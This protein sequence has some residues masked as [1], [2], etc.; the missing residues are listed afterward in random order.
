M[1]SDRPSGCSDPFVWE[2][3][4]FGDS[5]DWK[6][7][8]VPVNLPEDA[9][10]MVSLEELQDASLCWRSKR[11]VAPHKWQKGW[12]LW[13]CHLCGSSPT[14]GEGCHCQEA[15]A[16]VAPTMCTH[17]RCQRL[18]ATIVEEELE[19]AATFV[20]EELELVAP[21]LPINRQQESRVNWA[22]GER[23]PVENKRERGAA[24]GSSPAAIC[25]SVWE[26]WELSLSEVILLLHVCFNPFSISLIILT[27]PVDVGGFAEP[28]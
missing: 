12:L 21:F 23:K 19:L 20:E 3:V 25:S 13:Y 2:K 15:A 4:C 14:L 1:W 27:S 8:Q 28:R 18:A 11:T 22:E 24:K 7:W 6:V 16:G 9:F 5:G 17:P 26:Q 10:R